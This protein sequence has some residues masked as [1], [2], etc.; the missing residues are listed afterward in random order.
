[1]KSRLLNLKPFIVLLA[2][3]LLPRIVYGQYSQEVVTSN[4]R[5]YY[6]EGNLPPINL[7]NYAKLQIDI[8]GGG[9]GVSTSGVTTF[10]VGNRDVLTINQVTMGSGADHFAI[11]AYANPNG[12]TDIYITTTD[13]YAAFTM[14]ACMLQGNSTQLITI[15]QQTPVGT[16]LNPT[17]TPVFITDASGNIG[18]NTFNPKGYK[19][20]VNGSAVATSMTVKL[21]SAWPDYVFNPTYQLPSLS[22]VKAYIDQNQHLPEIPSD[23]EIAKDGLNLGEMNK[24]LLKKVEELTLYLIEKDKEVKAQSQNN[25]ALETKLKIQQEQIDRLNKK[26]EL[27]AGKTK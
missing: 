1:M 9:W 14:K 7:G 8:L 4:Q 23:Q 6:F 3:F 10:Y 5:P 13:D 24:L 26:M 16:L 20:A 25:Y 18:I 12:Y 15:V 11:K 19:F 17:I 2:I 21:N 22:E 27:L